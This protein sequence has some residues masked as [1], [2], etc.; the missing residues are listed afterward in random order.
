MKLMLSI[1]A[2][3]LSFSLSAQAKSVSCQS[4]E[5]VEGWKG[6]RTFDFA[7]FSAEIISNQEL[8]QAEINGAFAATVE[9][10][11]V[12]VK[13]DAAKSPYYTAYANFT[14]LEDAWCW[15]SPFLPKFMNDLESGR[16]FKGYINRVCEGGNRQNIALKCVIQ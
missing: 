11:T 3:A 10:S 4:L 7:N 5:K 12:I 1:F 14:S 16:E 2:V 6:F 13:E 9:K 15:Y 8:Q